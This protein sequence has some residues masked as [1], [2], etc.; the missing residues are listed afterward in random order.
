[1]ERHHL[2][3][4]KYWMVDVWYYRAKHG[5]KVIGKGETEDDALFAAAKSL[6]IKLW[7]EEAP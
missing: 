2:S 5:M 1:M 6:N 7:N 3:V 4:E